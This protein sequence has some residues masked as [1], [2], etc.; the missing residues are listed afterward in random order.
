M[1]Q[2]I[3]ALGLW[4]AT[5]WAAEPAVTNVSAEQRA[6]GMVVIHYDVA[7]DEGDA[8]NVRVEVSADGGAHFLVPARS[9]SGDVG[10]G[11]S[12]GAGKEI[13][14]DAPRDWDGEYSEQMVVQVIATDTLGFPGLEWTEEIPP[15]GFL[16]GQDG[17]AEGSGPARHV[18]IPYSYRLATREITRQQYCDFLNEALAG[19]K[20]ERS[21][22]TAV[23][24]ARTSEGVAKGAKLCALSDNNLRWNVSHFDVAE[25]YERFPAVVTWHGALL[26]CRTY[27]YDL[28]TTAEWE[29][30]ARGPDHDDEAEHLRYP[31]GDELDYTKMAGSSTVL[32][33]GSYAPNDYGLYDMCGNVAEW[34]RTL[35]ATLA[36]EAYPKREAVEGDLQDLSSGGARVARGLPAMPI[37]QWQAVGAANTW[38]GSTPMG[39]RPIQRN[40]SGS[41][42]EQLANLRL[43]YLW[44]GSDFLEAYRALGIPNST[45]VATLTVKGRLMHTGG[46]TLNSEG[47]AVVLGSGAEGAIPLT[48]ALNVPHL[49]VVRLALRNPTNAAKTVAVMFGDDVHEAQ[50]PANMETAG[51]LYCDNTTGALNMALSAAEA[52]VEVEE[53]AL[54]VT[55]GTS[56]SD[57]AYTFESWPT[58]SSALSA[59]GNTIDGE[60]WPTFRSVEVKS[61]GGVNGV[62]ALSYVPQESAY[63]SAPAVFFPTS[64]PLKRIKAVRILVMNRSSST[65]SVGLWGEGGVWSWSLDRPVPAL[66]DGY[67]SLELPIHNI[68]E[69]FLSKSEVMKFA[70]R[71]ATPGSEA[72]IFIKQ[73]DL[74]FEP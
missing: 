41:R 68:S 24:A 59:D 67:L 36:V 47:T 6:D 64:L 20:V 55:P 72:Q 18:H 44:R 63:D 28:P 43:A 66:T 7:D 5:V 48:S 19:G 29:K 10:D 65:F 23:V 21:G 71:G 57:R 39:F 40:G 16:M 62:A 61:A 37:W 14:W 35:G 45:S 52:G 12:P 26:F 13:V 60:F 38:T 22:T 73:I 25:G 1:K 70:F 50:L 11:I 4:G 49:E 46:I 9:F 53:I 33:V 8:L 42:V 15:S 58:G 3:L 51:F 34:T 2:L 32:A 56:L 54:Y 17:G 30:A 27:G 74:E 31:W 69:E